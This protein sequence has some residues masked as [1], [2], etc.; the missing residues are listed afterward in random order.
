MVFVLAVGI[1]PVDPA[2][3]VTKAEVDAACADSQVAYTAYSQAQSEFNRAAEALMEAELQLDS[4]ERREQR[5]RDLVQA[6]SDDHTRLQ[7]SANDQAA[8]LYMEGVTGSANA[9][10]FSNPVEALTATDFLASVTDAGLDTLND[11]TATAADLERLRT[12]LAV[13]AD[14][15]VV[16]RQQRQDS[17]AAQEKAMDAALGAY[18]DLDDD[19]RDL[20]ADYQAEQARIRAEEAARRQRE[21]G[22]TSGGQVVTGTIC[23]FKPG[24]TQFIDSW[25]YPRSGGRSHKGADMFA[26]WDEPI[27][28]V[29]SGTVVTGNYGLGG[30][31]IWLTANDGSAYY[32]AHLNSQ[33]V[34]SGQR[35]E[36]GQLI[37]YNGNSGNAAGL[38]PHVHL[39][40]HPSGRGGPAV[41]PYPT[42]AGACF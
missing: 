13:A 25:G 35:V 6:R 22:G 37:G 15:L 39:Q 12:E 32:Y 7:A 19:C 4:L 8:E 21:T 33:T 10:F 28:A 2:G 29:K 24:R 40:I 16:V 42:V 11:L 34:S 36:Q 31:I 38:S 26:P 1:V 41:N 23:P 27:Y 20:Q 30:K 3:A 5:V 18:Q 9:L 14:E 17:A